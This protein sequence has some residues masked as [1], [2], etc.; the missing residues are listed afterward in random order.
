MRSAYVDIEPVIYASFLQQ[1]E[2]Y[3]GPF[4]AMFGQMTFVLRTAGNP[5]SLVPAARR[6]VAEIEPNRP[7]AFPYQRPDR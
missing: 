4:A 2:Q 3:R 6:A 5:T 1:S 7:L